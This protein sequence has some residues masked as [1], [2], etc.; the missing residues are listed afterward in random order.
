MKEIEVKF[1]VKE[2][3]T[4][5]EKLSK[6]GFRV[7][8]ARHCEKNYPFDDAAG[9][10]KNAGKLLRVR[11]TPSTKTVSFKGP[12]SADSKLKQREEIECRIES[13]ETIIRIL[14]EAGFRIRGGYSK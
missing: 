11:N 4:I 12:I 13:A 10:L 8:V 14:E 2:T 1:P 7:A 3:R 6:L 5:T 9:N